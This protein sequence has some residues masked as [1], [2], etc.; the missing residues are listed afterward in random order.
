MSRYREHWQRSLDSLSRKKHRD[1]EDILRDIKDYTL[2]FRKDVKEL[3]DEYK[4]VRSSSSV[5]VIRDVK[6]L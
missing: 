5:P 2:R 3:E 4:S 6:E 1:P